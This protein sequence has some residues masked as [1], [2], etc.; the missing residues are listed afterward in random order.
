[1]ISDLKPL[2]DLI[3]IL[4]LNKSPKNAV[5]R[6]ENMTPLGK[7]HKE[8]GNLNLACDKSNLSNAKLV[9]AGT[10]KSNNT[11]KVMNYQ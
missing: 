11:S 3:Q 1:M 5:N 8:S 2:E 6:K 4:H 9:R 10:F 7:S